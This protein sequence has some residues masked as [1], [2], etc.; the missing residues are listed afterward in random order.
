MALHVNHQRLA[1][2][3]DPM[4]TD[5]AVFVHKVGVFLR[6]NFNSFGKFLWNGNHVVVEQVG[7]FHAR[8][9]HESR[10]ERVALLQALFLAFLRC[11]RGER[12]DENRAVYADGK[13]DEIVNISSV[14]KHPKFI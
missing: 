9:F 8:R 14:P 11:L 4:L 5:I 10:R 13:P 6:V 1:R 12:N 2:D 7:N 3:F